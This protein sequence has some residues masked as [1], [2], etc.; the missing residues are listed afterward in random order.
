MNVLAIPQSSDVSN[1]TKPVIILSPSSTSTPVNSLCKLTDGNIG[2]IQNDG[3]TC[4]SDCFSSDSPG[5]LSP[6][7]RFCT[8]ITKFVVGTVCQYDEIFFGLIASDGFTCKRECVYDEQYPGYLFMDF[9]DQIPFC[10]PFEYPSTPSKDY[11]CLT[12][13][14]LFGVIQEDGVCST[15]CMDDYS[16]LG[17]YDI[18]GVTCNTF[19]GFSDKFYCLIDKQTPGRF[20]NGTCI[21]SGCTYIDDAMEWHSD[22][23]VARNFRCVAPGTTIE[24]EIS[25][26]EPCLTEDQQPGA[27]SQG[28]CSPECYTDYGLEG[29]RGDDWRCYPVTSTGELGLLDEDGNP[30][31]NGDSCISGDKPGFIDDYN[32][33]SD[34]AV[35]DYQSGFLANN[36]FDC[37]P[38]G[39]ESPPLV[40]KNNCITKDNSPGR[41]IEA[42]GICSSECS[43]FGRKGKF[44]MFFTCIV[45]DPLYPCITPS[46]TPGKTIYGN[47]EAECTMT[48]NSKGVISSD[49][50]SCVPNGSPPIQNPKENS[51]CVTGKSEAAMIVN[52]I[53]TSVCYLND[54]S[55]GKISSDFKFCESLTEPVADYGMPCVIDGKPGEFIDDVCNF[56]CDNGNGVISSDFYE[57]VQEGTPPVPLV[58]SDYC[59][60]DGKAGVVTNGICSNSCLINTIYPGTLSDFFK[61]E[62][63]EAPEVKTEGFACKLNE[64][65]GRY[66]ENGDCKITCEENGVM[67]LYSDDSSYCL[68]AQ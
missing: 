15:K 20:K 54:N 9:Y 58:E 53:C 11:Y 6:D 46:G 21:S 31:E 68:V 67:G 16:N 55:V 22:G 40:D 61:C 24:E 28:V 17:S 26:G 18:D 43:A 29:R 19:N 23:V 45:E 2:R 66:D 25:E 60:I 62:P 4:S 59:V 1:S 37:L 41:Y 36:F 38:V 64:I 48:D 32:C 27:M 49:F 33:Y 13:M 7:G 65:P 56:E 30:P 63:M 52:G 51:F 42:E 12:N 10:I 14:K 35:D 47:C 44:S 57:C 5:K 8:P 39:S 3:V 50:D 34:C